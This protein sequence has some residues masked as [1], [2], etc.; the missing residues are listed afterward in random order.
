MVY[1]K[2]FVSLE[3][4]HPAINVLCVLQSVLTPLRLQVTP[5]LVEVKAS[6]VLSIR[7]QRRIAQLRAGICLCPQGDG[8]GIGALVVNYTWREGESCLRPDLRN[9]FAIC[10]RKEEISV[11][12][13]EMWG[14]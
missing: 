7:E 10:G 12:A 11:S 3:T 6:L 5:V 14:S 2:C 4:D 1:A 9:E 8:D 13:C